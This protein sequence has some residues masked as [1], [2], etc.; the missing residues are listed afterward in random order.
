LNTPSELVHAFVDALNVEDEA[1]LEALCTHKGWA[2]RGDSI[3][4][5][6]RQ[7]I[8]GGLRFSPLAEIVEDDCRAAVCGLLSAHR[9]QRSHGRLW[10]TAVKRGT[11]R[12]EGCAKSDRAA[13]L[14]ASGV[15]PAIFDPSTLP[16]SV[17]ADQWAAQI[18]HAALRGSVEDPRVADGLELLS[19]D[20]EGQLDLMGSHQIASIGRH[21]AGFGRRHGP[22][23]VRQ[24][25]WFA[26]Q[27]DGSGKLRVLG[28]SV[29]AGQALLLTETTG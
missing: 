21:V 19:N 14:F 16:Q 3:G 11:W 13:A 26:L 2:G 12:L 25:V 7:A 5:F 22:D 15:L 27:T 9:T 10:L 20:Q 1:A 28:H 24:E 23:D 8:R 18:L 6:V 4:R 29:G 17:Q